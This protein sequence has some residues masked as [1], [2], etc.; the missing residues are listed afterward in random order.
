MGNKYN[1]CN[2]IQI[3]SSY[4]VRYWGKGRGRGR[5]KE[6]RKGEES[7]R[8]FREK[9]EKMKKEAAKSEV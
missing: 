3:Y 1:V 5:E 9:K 6:K 7:A 8:K 4:K 2:F